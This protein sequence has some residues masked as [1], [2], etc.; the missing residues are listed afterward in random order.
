MDEQDRALRALVAQSCRCGWPALSDTAAALTAI[1]AYSAQTQAPNFT[2]AIIVDGKTVATGGPFNYAAATRTFTLPALSKGS[3]ALVLRKN[4]SGVLHYVVS[5]T[6]KLGANAPES[7]VLAT[8][9]IAPQGDPLQLPAGNVYDIG[10]QIAVDHPVDRVVITDPLPAGFEA[11]DTSFQTT[12]SYYQPLTQAWE[13][14]YQ[15]VYQDRVTAYAQHLDPGVYVLHYLVRSVTP[16]EYIWPG[17]N[18]YLLDAPEQF[19]RS[20]FRSV[21]V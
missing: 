7:T 10:V 11:L 20:A 2:V 13:I 3:H 8:V 14:D 18:A 15:Q 17:S 1:A 19:G 6:Y 5:Y 16:G 4:G 9:D 12:A 21:K